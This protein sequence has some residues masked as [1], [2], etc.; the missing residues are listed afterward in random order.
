MDQH[1]V[2]SLVPA[3]VALF[4]TAQCSNTTVN[5]QNATKHSQTGW[6]EGPD[7]RG[8]MTILWSCLTIIISCTWTILHLNVPHPEEGAFTK[9]FR[10][11]K[12]MVINIL[13]PEFI[14][15]KAVCELQMAVD[16]L[17]A[18][19]EKEAE[20]GGEVEFGRGA[21]CL[22]RLFHLLDGRADSRVN[23]ETVQT[24]KEDVAAKDEP[25]SSVQGTGG[26]SDSQDN[27]LFDKSRVWTL[28]HSYLSNMGGLYWYQP[29]IDGIRGSPLTA[30]ALVNCCIDNG[31]S[32]LS[33]LAL[34]EEDIKDKSKADWFVK[35]FAV[36]Q[37]S[38]LV[39]SVITRAAS[40]LATSQLEICTVAFAILAV[41]TYAA[42]WSKPKDVDMPV[43]FGS[44]TQHEYECN[45]NEYFGTSF[46]EQFITPLTKTS[47]KS[48][49]WMP[50]EKISRIKNDFIRLDRQGPT[51]STV[52]AISTAAFGGLHF[53]AWNTEFPTK[54]E[55][56]I[57][58]VASGLSIVL[59]FLNLITNAIILRGIRNQI[60][61]LSRAIKKL[62]QP[63]TPETTATSTDGNDQ[64]GEVSA[65][66][67]VYQCGLV[68]IKTDT[69]LSLWRHQLAMLDRNLRSFSRRVSAFIEGNQP[70]LHLQSFIAE[71]SKAWMSCVNILNRSPVE[72]LYPCDPPQPED[73]I[74]PNVL[75]PNDKGDVPKISEYDWR[76]MINLL[77]HYKEV[78]E[79][80]QFTA[81]KIS[82]LDTLSRFLTII[83]GIIYAIARLLILVLAFIA[84]RRQDE[85]VYIDTWTKVLPNFS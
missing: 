11:A 59:P 50:T 14:F 83:T 60:L 41:A 48:R 75:M 70:H 25:K 45:A 39:L 63:T 29:T 26:L 71:Y 53:L 42:N 13:F 80:A 69:D 33:L 28:S 77:S 16:D 21:R 43:R 68:R 73:E 72:L 15:S 27:V 24:A 61:V 67:R 84:L 1:P 4:A 79:W 55:W 54:S 46:F 2:L 8:T 12:W 78:H 56:I 40:N 81:K 65:V 30:H 82:P 57:W 85:R 58:M 7:G 35:A 9:V 23:S 3:L 32:F 52:M 74:Y 22:Y 66:K 47:K 64:E 17:H 18:M 20:T 38:W 10:K 34:S 5:A 19:K 62:P 6:R 36:V 44:R 31:H 37:I 76:L 49:E 51:I